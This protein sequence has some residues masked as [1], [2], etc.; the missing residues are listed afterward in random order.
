MSGMPSLML[1]TGINI[2]INFGVF[3]TFL[4][5]STV[6]GHREKDTIQT[7]FKFFVE[8]ITCLIYDFSGQQFILR[9]LNLKKSIKK[10]MSS[11]A[12]CEKYF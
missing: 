4:L 3:S 12:I 5:L 1:E 8:N 7:T 2:I 10:K 9:Y 6:S 11:Q